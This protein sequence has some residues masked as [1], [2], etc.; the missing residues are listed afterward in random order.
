M[1][2]VYIEEYRYKYEYI[3]ISYI[4]KYISARSVIGEIF[5]G[6]GLQ[7]LELAKREFGKP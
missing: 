4:Y 3:Y 6:G 7:G 5:F 2:L 1:C